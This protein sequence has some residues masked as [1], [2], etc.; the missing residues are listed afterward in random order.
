MKRLPTLLLRYAILAAG[1]VVLS[2]CGITAYLAFA[3]VHVLT[4]I[5]FGGVCLAAAPFFIA[6]FQANKLIGYIDAGK[7]FS[8]LSVKALGIIMR[9]AV[10]VFIVCTAG[11][12][13]FFYTVAQ[14]QDA[15]GLMLIGMAIAG[16][17][18]VIAVFA[19]VLT[20]LLQ[21]AIAMKKENDLTI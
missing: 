20:R 8:D 3:E 15:P 19:S 2:I 1:A 21:E 12:L 7:A 5:L 10:A 4:S 17:A 9:C 13:P 14:L 18:F 16:A 11:G 6:L